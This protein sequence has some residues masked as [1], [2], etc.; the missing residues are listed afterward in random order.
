MRPMTAACEHAGRRTLSVK[1]SW[2]AP[3]ELAVRLACG[4]LDLFPC[5]FLVPVGNIR[6]DGASEQN[7][8]LSASKRQPISSWTQGLG[9]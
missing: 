7:G 3:Y 8:I 6:R 5:S 9:C 4:G 2:E 1:S